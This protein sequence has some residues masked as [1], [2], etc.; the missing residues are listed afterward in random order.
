MSVVATT[1]LQTD[2]ERQVE[3]PW[4]LKHLGTPR[5]ILDVGTGR[6]ATYLDAL[7]ATGARVYAL[8]YRPVPVPETVHFVAGLLG[9]TKLPFPDG[10]FDAI[11]CISTLDHIGLAAYGLVENLAIL[12]DAPAALSRL[13]C[14]GGRL[15]LTV[16]TG[17]DQITTHPE[18]GQRVFGRA[19]LKQM[20]ALPTWVLR[21]ED[22]WLLDG[23]EYR[24][25]RV[26]DV[27]NVDYAGHRA[28]A[29]LAWELERR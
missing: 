6:N 26:Q 16:P 28:G 9:L 14:P 15:L 10:Y 5:C 20:F 22:Y 11:T 3:V 2:T 19:A 12:A 29:C 7:A 17:R 4:V 18:G 21:A 1:W 27:T 8:D 23:E 25:A 13:L 24:P